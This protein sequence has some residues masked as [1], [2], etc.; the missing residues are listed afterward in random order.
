[1]RAETRHQLKEDAFSRTTIDA[2]ESAVHWTVEHKS[3]LLTGFAV[4]AVLLI[5][6]GGAWYYLSQQDEKASVSLSQA[7]RTLQEPI[8]PAG[9]PPQPDYPSFASVDERAT[10]ARK[11]F[12][13]VIDKY[14]HTH[15]ADVARYFLGTVALERGDNATAERELK[16]V[17]GTQ[18]RDLV[19]LAKLALATV[20][21]NTNRTKDA[22]DLYKQLVDKPTMTVNKVAAQ[23]K[24]ADLYENSQQP[25][26]AKRIYEQIQKENPGSEMAALAQS[27]LQELK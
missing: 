15:T 21:T 16:E 17:I 2:A 14:P 18:N 20:Y 13:E 24:L 5:A 12:Q 22:V 19:A 11:Q 7:I 4:L 6:G 10:T 3:K 27:K 1:V 26:E 9:M 23:I 8:R 25:L